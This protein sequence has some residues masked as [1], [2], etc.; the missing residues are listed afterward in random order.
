MQT[1]T[2][3]SVAVDSLYDPLNVPRGNMPGEE[4]VPDPDVDLDPDP[5]MTEPIGE[6]PV[7]VP[8]TLDPDDDLDDDPYSVDPIGAPPN[9][10]DDDLIDPINPAIQPPREVI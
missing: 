1:Q 6:P 9:G 2:I 4:G 5:D 7:S 10:A 8:P 3:D